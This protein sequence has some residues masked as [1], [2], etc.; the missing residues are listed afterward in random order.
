MRRRTLIALSLVFGAWLLTTS[1][2]AAAPPTVKA[3]AHAVAKPKTKS[4]PH[5]APR[6]APR[7][8]PKRHRSDA[9]FPPN[10]ESTRGYTY[11]QMTRDMCLREL[12]TR[13]LAATPSTQTYAGLDAPVRLTGKLNDVEFRTLFVGEDGGPSV[14]SLIDCRLVLA[15]DDVSKTLHELGITE[16]Q[17][18]S[19]Y[20]PPP[21]GTPEGSQ[22]RRHSGGLAI[23]VHRFKSET[24]GWLSVEKDFHGRLGAKVCGPKAAPPAPATPNALHLRKIVCSVAEAHLF[25]SILTPNYDRPHR[26]HIHFEVTQTVRWYIV[27]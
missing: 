5:T 17:F 27:S 26:N 16:V 13:H 21:K 1:D 25:Q 9:T 18:S 4:R 22:G 15:L 2:G 11:A 3:K 7:Q 14:Y 20:R 12:E 6:R 19:A 24:L 10:V 8:S 23:D